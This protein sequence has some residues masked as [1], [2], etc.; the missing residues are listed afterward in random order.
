MKKSMLNGKIKPLK[1]SAGTQTY[2]L[3]RLIPGVT[4]II[5]QPQNGGSLYP[6][7]NLTYLS[8]PEQFLMG[9]KLFPGTFLIKTNKV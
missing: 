3:Q 9:A 6:A 8:H 7:S 4:A 5:N 1:L 2:Y